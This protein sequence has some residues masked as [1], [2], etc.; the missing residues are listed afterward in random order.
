MTVGPT[1][2]LWALNRRSLSKLVLAL[3][4]LNVQLR[5]VKILRQVSWRL[6]KWYSAIFFLFNSCLEYSW[7]L[8]RF[9]T[10]EELPFSFYV[11]SSSFSF[12]AFFPLARLP[13]L[14]RSMHL[15]MRERRGGEALLHTVESLAPGSKT[16]IGLKMTK[17]TSSSLFCWRLSPAPQQKWAQLH[18]SWVETPLLSFSAFAGHNSFCF[19]RKSW[20]LHL[21]RPRW[22]LFPRTLMLFI[23]VHFIKQFVNK[24]LYESFKQSASLNFSVLGLQAITCPSNRCN[25]VMVP[26]EERRFTHPYVKCIDCQVQFTQCGSAVRGCVC[27]RVCDKFLIN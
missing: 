10:T 6:E 5:A 16:V 12:S 18:L 4:A 27:S 13:P 25:A 9:G 3:T 19:R 14:S 8:S 17:M 26:P 24:E 22:L 1:G 21:F 15:F 2:L 23:D 7:L 11:I 20:Q